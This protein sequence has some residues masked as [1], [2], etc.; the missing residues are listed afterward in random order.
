MQLILTS[1]RYR[2]RELLEQLRKF[3]DFYQTGFRDVIRG[4]VENPEAFLKDLEKRD[5]F[6]LARIAPTETSF[7]FSPASVV[8]EF[9]EAVK[10][11]LNEIR[12]G[13]SFCVKVE[14]RGLTGAFSSQEIAKEIG[15]FISKTLEERDKEKPKVNLRDPDKA[16]VFETLGKWCGVGIV[17]KDMRQRYF[18]LKLP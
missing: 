5:V 17:S 12:K 2:E 9:C 15:T 11:L 18:Y 14:R 7:I 8:E 6:A 10:P 1:H 3:G 13:E 16:F 4:E